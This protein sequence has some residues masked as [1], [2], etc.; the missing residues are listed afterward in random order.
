MLSVTSSNGADGFST[1]VSTGAAGV[2]LPPKETI[3]PL[4]LT[5]LNVIS[6]VSSF[7]ENSLSKINF[8]LVGVSITVPSIFNLYVKSPLAEINSGTAELVLTIACWSYVFSL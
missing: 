3:S 4:S 7:F 5:L 2:S 8:P 6:T 1:V